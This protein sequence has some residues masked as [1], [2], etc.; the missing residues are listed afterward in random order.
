[1]T[2]NRNLSL[3]TP[4]VS[5][6]GTVNNAGLTNSSVTINGTSVSLGGTATITASVANALTIGTG[7]S[8][9]SYNG[10]SAVT[11]AL[12]SNYGDTTNPYAS[13]TANYFLAAP[14][15]TAGAPTFRAIV[16]ADI[17]TLNQNTTG[18]AAGLSGSQTANYV[19]A[20][21]NGT[22]GTASFRALVAADVPTLNQNTT[23]TAANVTGIVAIANGGS[24]QT[25]AQA[26]MNAFAGAVTSGSYL[27]G[28]GTNVVMSAIQA[29]D[30]PTLNQN[31][32]G[33][34]GSVANALT[35][36][37]GLSGSSY[38]GSSAVT[39]ALN[40]TAVT[41]GSY[42]N[43][44]ITVDA[45][46][47]ITAAAN[48]TGGGGG[49]GSAITVSDEGT[50][51]TSGVTSF[52]FVGSGVTA[53]NSGN[54]VTVTIPGGGGSAF[55][56]VILNDISNQFNNMNCVFPLRLEQDDI[57]NSN[58]S[59]SKNLEVII[60]GLRLSPYIVQQTYPWMTPYDSFKG[61]RVVTTAT[62]ANLII[63][64][65]PAMGD[66]ASVTIINNSSTIQTRKYPY[67]ATTIALGD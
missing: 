62:S 42:T 8:G 41:P 38:N 32:T 26:A 58:V 50:A 57:T 22:A 27:R 49:G 7:L 1:M 53:T 20:A 36:G 54:A 35:I 66:S 59:D 37:T 48:G 4:N 15:G 60:N 67:S 29:G 21:P 9:S 47:R 39:I 61:F 34:A 46:G 13:K 43:A 45:Q 24:G 40:N 51:L 14:N 55:S 11:I 5:A 31:T 63:Y 17:P 56:P 65:A 16:A 19:Y 3:L 6:T 18:T 2:I 12:A 52:N 33:S 44:D 25:T 28:N 10:S 64:N 23:G 30:V